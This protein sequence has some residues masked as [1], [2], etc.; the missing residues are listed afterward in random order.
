MLYKENH[1]YLFLLC[2]NRPLERT[3]ELQDQAFINAGDSCQSVTWPVN[4][5]LIVAF[6]FPTMCLLLFGIEWQRLCSVSNVEVF[7]FLVPNNVWPHSLLRAVLTAPHYLP[8]FLFHYHQSV[9]LAHF[10][11]ST[12]T[13]FSGDALCPFMLSIQFG[14]LR[15][16]LKIN[17]A[18]MIC[19]R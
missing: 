1:T 19:T 13:E 6:F 8:L 10:S 15:T 2:N 17:S 16:F 5:W 4:I 12:V 11:R 3:L 14:A 7:F 18:V 9:L